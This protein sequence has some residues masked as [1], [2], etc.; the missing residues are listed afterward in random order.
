VSI[1]FV[2][3]AVEWVSSLFVLFPFLGIFALIL[4]LV[5][6]KRTKRWFTYLR[7]RE[8]LNLISEEDSSGEKPKGSPKRLKTWSIIGSLPLILITLI[9]FS[10]LAFLLL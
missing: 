4:A 1:P 7:E 3:L 5:F 6:G 2:I 9:G 8:E 10:F